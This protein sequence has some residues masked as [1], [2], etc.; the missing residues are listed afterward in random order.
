MRP[1]LNWHWKE[2]KAMGVSQFH[3]NMCVDDGFPNSIAAYFKAHQ[4]PLPSANV[5]CS[6]FVLA[7]NVMYV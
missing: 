3:N 7:K 1:V 4:A 5:L 6:F 2:T